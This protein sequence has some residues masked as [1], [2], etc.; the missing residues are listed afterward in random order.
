MDLANGDAALLHCDHAASWARENGKHRY[1]LAGMRM[2]GRGPITLLSSC[3]RGI[4]FFSLYDG[5]A[6]RV[7]K[8]RT[9]RTFLV[10]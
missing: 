6:G 5:S 9:A 2:G 7:H 8:R 4:E 3:G 1:G 10:G